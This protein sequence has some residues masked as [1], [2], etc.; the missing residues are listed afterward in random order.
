MSFVS[1]KTSARKGFS[2][3]VLLSSEKKPTQHLLKYNW[4]TIP[5][6][7]A[8]LH[9]DSQNVLRHITDIFRKK[10]LCAR[11]Y[12]HEWTLQFKASVPNCNKCSW[13]KYKMY[14]YSI[15]LLLIYPSMYTYTCTEISYLKWI[16]QMELFLC[17]KQDILIG[18][19]SQNFL[20]YIL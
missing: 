2:E 3:E 14:M 13:F 1:R 9:N 17:F 12:P 20:Q 7:L 6:T 18:K 19:G 15:K 10:F 5:N 11:F 8:Y 16:F 4:K